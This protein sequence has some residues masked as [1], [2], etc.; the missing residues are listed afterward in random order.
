MP[1][2][3]LITKLLA[4]GPVATDGAWGTQLQ[5]RGLLPGEFPD[6]WNL[7]QPE[8]VAEVPQAYVQAGS[9]VILT[10]TFGANRVR[11][12]EIGMS[13]RVAEINRCGVEISRNAAEGQALVFASV[14][15][16]GKLLM[17]GDI[18]PEEV[19]TAFEEQ[20]A[21]LADAGADALVIET[22]TDLAEAELAVAAA[23]RTGLPVVACM[24]FDC[25]KAKDRTMMGQT[26]EQ[27]TLALI[28]AGA[29]VIGANCGQGIA[30]FIPTCRR[31]KTAASVPIWIKANAGLPEMLD[32][33]IV[34]RT[35]PDEFGGH[36]K[37]LVNAG[38]DF[39]GGC[40]GTSPEFIRAVRQQLPSPR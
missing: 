39:I 30:G 24:V 21:A 23:R 12:A 15:P 31:L 14:G 20:T 27:T 18:T 4:N 28:R 2:N 22:M 26:P 11:L 1:M 6:V 3:P 16:T 38:A 35:S 9:T 5:Q 32:G 25:G 7:T 17:T 36:V 10:N 37:E 29:D 19:Q 40:C 33:K 8:R 34:Y 13:D